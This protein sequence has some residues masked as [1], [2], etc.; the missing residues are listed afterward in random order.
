MSTLTRNIY[1]FV[2]AGLLLLT[3]S[4][5]ASAQAKELE[6]RGSIWVAATAQKKISKE[7]K[8]FV[9]PQI[10]TKGWEPQR[11]LLEVGLKYSP[12][13]FLSL[14]TAYRAGLEKV[15]AD[16]I[17]ARRIRFDAVASGT[18]LRFRPSLRVRYTDTYS[19]DLPSV[20]RIRYK[21]VL[22]YRVKKFPLTPD[23]SLEAFQSLKTAEFFKMRYGTGASY[24]FYKKK[25]VRQFVR[26]AYH[27]E[28]R[29]D[30]Y[31]NTHVARLA[32]KVTF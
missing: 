1:G 13:K 7:V 31:R 24:R 2:L 30:K 14:R 15:F 3:W 23:V 22:A 17:F 25:K 4:S 6:T 12:W 18:L 19:P 20:H 26:I 11:Y 29:L 28:Y 27:L 16:P 10:R 8:V 32:Y 21:G 9:L 5:P